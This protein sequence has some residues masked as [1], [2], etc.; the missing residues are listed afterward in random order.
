M[1]KFF[2]ARKWIPCAAF[3]GCGVA[4]G[5]LAL[6]A[7]GGGS[8]YP[9][10]LLGRPW[11]VLDAPA[12]IFPTEIERLPFEAAR[13]PRSTASRTAS[14]S[15]PTAWAGRPV[16]TSVAA[17]PK[18]LCLSMPAK[19]GAATGEPC[20]RSSLSAGRWRKAAR[21]PWRPSPTTRRPGRCSPPT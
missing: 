17:I 1:L 6:W 21:T 3:A 13:S 2:H 18:R 19:R 12:G 4:I 16:P 5:T 8:R 11:L 14:G 15:P 20:C 10:W 9:E 7:C